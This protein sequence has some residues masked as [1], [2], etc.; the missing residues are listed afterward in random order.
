M[1]RDSLAPASVNAFLGVSG[2]NQLVFERR[3][4]DHARAWQLRRNLANGQQW[5]K[6]ARHGK[7]IT[8]WTSANGTDWNF[9]WL[10]RL[11]FE[12]TSLAG[13]AA[14]AAPA[15]AVRADFDSVR[16]SSTS[17][18][19]A[20]ASSSEVDL[21]IQLV[22]SE[23]QAN[24]DVG[25]QLLVYGA[26]GLQGVL[27]G[28]TDLTQWSELLRFSCEEDPQ[29]FEEDFQPARFYRVRPFVP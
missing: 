21:G 10:A 16:I 15:N 8:A 26:P 27:E 25:A 1:L 9:V 19:Q 18:A 7:V 23:A 17:I 13:L 4:P 12:S 5:L 28:S 22:A 29:D 11:P 3:K 2:N 20:A 6:L 24:L 14:S